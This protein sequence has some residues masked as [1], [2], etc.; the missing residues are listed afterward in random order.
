MNSILFEDKF[1]YDLWIKIISDRNRQEERDERE[2]ITKQ[3][4]SIC[5]KFE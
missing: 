5:A 1:E 3:A 4:R 2:D